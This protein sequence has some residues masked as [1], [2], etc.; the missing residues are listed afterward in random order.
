M[1]TLKP[2]IF[3]RFKDEQ[4]RNSSY[5]GLYACYSGTVFDAYRYRFYNEVAPIRK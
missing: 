5:L 3:A 4:L 2:M 1:T